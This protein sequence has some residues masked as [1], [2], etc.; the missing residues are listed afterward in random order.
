[1]GK[2][3]KNP[4]P[5]KPQ[6]TVS[7]VTINQL[8]R[9]EPIK[10]CLEHVNNQTYKNII[11][12]VIVEG[13][14][15]LEDCLENEKNIPFLKENCKIPIVYVPGYTLDDSGNKIFN[16]NKLG[17]LRNLGNTTCTGDITVVHDDDD[18]IPPTRVS[19]SVEMLMGSKCLIAGCSGKYLYDYQL[20]KMY[21]F[22]PFGPNH[23]TNDC[24]AWKKEYL[25]ENSHD[26]TKEMAEESSF[27]KNFANPMVQLDPKHV[28]VSSSH[29]M[30]TFSKKEICIFACIG[31][32][33]NATEVPL[34]E[35]IFPKKYLDRY[36]AL[37]TQ[38]GD[39]DYDIIYFT[40]GTSI[41]WDPNDQSLGGSEQA[42][43]NLATEWVH[44]GKKVAVYGKLKTVG[45]FNGIDYIDWKTFDYDKRYKTVILW[46]MA[47]INC[48]LQF[49]IKAERLYADLHDNIYTFRFDYPKYAHKLNKIFFKSEYHVECYEA[50]LGK[51]EPSKVV[52][53]PNG[54]RVEQFN[55]EPSDIKRNP[56]RFCYCSCYTRGLME[57]LTFIWPIIFK[58]EPRAELHV[59]YGMNY[60]QDPNFKQQMVMLL[61]QPGVMDHGRQPMELIIREKWQSTFH[62]YITDTVGE[63][64]CISIRE[65]LVSGCIPLL[66]DFG[67]F[68]KRE[69][70]RFKL[71]RQNQQSYLQ[72]GQGILNLLQKPDFI[73]MC[74]N[75]FKESPTITT[76]KQTAEQW[77]AI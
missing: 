46:R 22:K 65:S 59:Y 2:K 31:I 34:T 20:E 1:M 27:C 8:K 50:A 49:P 30:N 58:Y 56:Y 57:I 73:Y 76:W 62:L 18:E 77:L 53:I 23:S 69:G 24:M 35:S 70:L 38:P 72:I 54:I 52:I 14:Q 43:V 17:A 25:L 64:D 44:L 47:G 9:V 33:P 32:Y 74:R 68:A 55:K 48:M 10:I 42:V 29:Y 39:S 63:I 61:A 45:T 51:L 15:N 16:N 67:V 4:K 26:P 41:E 13:S 21:L 3:S 5:E 6:P 36:K 11:E 60:V 75:R 19:H 12:W 28:I 40:G 66:S 37:Y 71:D 7:I